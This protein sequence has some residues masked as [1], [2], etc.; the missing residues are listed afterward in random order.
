M[1]KDRHASALCVQSRQK[2]L[3]ES[4]EDENTITSNALGKS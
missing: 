3:V 1:H 2:S 4:I